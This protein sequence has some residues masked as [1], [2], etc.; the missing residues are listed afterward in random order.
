VN[1]DSGKNI[2]TIKSIQ[3][4]KD[5]VNLCKLRDRVALS[6][7][8]L[9]IGRQANEGEIF[10]VDIPENDFRE[11]K[12]WA[13]FLTKEEKAVLK[14]LAELKRKEFSVWGV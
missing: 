5:S 14:E 6:I 9:T 2:G 13:K 8:H 1:A 10:L 4:N 11:L 7:P 3:K 12:K